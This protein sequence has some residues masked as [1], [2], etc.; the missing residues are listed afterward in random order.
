[1]CDNLINLVSNICN[2]THNLLLLE[3]S[4]VIFAHGLLRKTE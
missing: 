2:Y 1:M 4:F 3:L